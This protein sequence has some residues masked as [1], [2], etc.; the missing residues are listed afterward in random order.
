[1]KKLELYKKRCSELND[2]IQLKRQEFNRENTLLKQQIDFL[3]K[4][5]ESLQVVLLENQRNYEER[6]FSLREEM[7]KTHQEKLDRISEEKE[8]L[9]GKLNLKKAR[10][11]R[12]SNKSYEANIN[13]GKRKG[14]FK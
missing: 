11:E 3:D 9:E 1:M 4:K 12:T 5:N 13:N 6:L 8:N 2:E 7:D 14:N 10:N